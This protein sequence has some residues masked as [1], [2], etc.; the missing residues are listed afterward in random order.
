MRHA[1]CK[2][3]F[4]FFLIYIFE[5]FTGSKS[6]PRQIKLSPYL[7]FFDVSN[8]Y[9]AHTTGFSFVFHS[10]F[11][12]YIETKCIHIFYIGVINIKCKKCLSTL[13]CTIYNKYDVRDANCWG[14]L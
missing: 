2:I 7:H 12:Y 11:F 9:F 10:F 6:V 5:I 8:G 13:K 1:V 14:K 4:I 3:G